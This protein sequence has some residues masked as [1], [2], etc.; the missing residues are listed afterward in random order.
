MSLPTITTA[1]VEALARLARLRFTK[2][3][4][5][6]LTNEL[7]TILGHMREL[8]EVDVTGVPPT[9]HVTHPAM[10]EAPL[11]A[12]EPAPGLAHDAALAGAP[13]VSEGGF[14]VPAFV[15]QD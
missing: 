4:A 7:H 12:D 11:R 14:A 5:T 1:E 13:R 2:E 9:T 10:A 15:D 3:E 8:A 6:Q